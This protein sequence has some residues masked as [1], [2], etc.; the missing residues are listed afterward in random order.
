MAYYNLTSRLQYAQYNVDIAPTP[1]KT[2]TPVVAPIVGEPAAVK[3]EK[4]E[5]GVELPPAE[6]EAE[7]TTTSIP[8]GQAEPAH[9]I[10]AA[11]EVNKPNSDTIPVAQR[12]PEAPREA[13]KDVSTDEQLTTDSVEASA[14][15]SS[16][17]ESG[18]SAGNGQE[19][20]AAAVDPTGTLKDTSKEQDGDAEAERVR[21]ELFPDEAGTR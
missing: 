15:D 20:V 17:V 6:A 2:P 5:I 7:S 16:L 18:T 14:A 8:F 3:E 12:E 21:K 10:F 9:D 4:I 19:T 13:A 1:V 11:N